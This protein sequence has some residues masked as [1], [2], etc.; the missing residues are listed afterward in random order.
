MNIVDAFDVIFS[1]SGKDQGQVEYCFGS[2]CWG[3][4]SERR[5]VMNLVIKFEKDNPEL[6]IE[7]ISVCYFGEIALPKW[8]DQQNGKWS[9]EDIKVLRQG[10]NFI[11]G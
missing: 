1:F 11:T 3:Y 4:D 7:K 6:I 5:F 10:F 2:W 9:K 8:Y